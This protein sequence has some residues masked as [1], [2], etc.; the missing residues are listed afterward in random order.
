MSTKTQR[1]SISV[2]KRRNPAKAISQFCDPKEVA[3]ALNSQYTLQFTREPSGPLPDIV[4]QPVTPMPEIVF[5]VPGI[6][7]L[8]CNLNPAKASGPDLVPARILKLAS[9]EIV[10]ILCTIFQQS[11][12][13]SKVPLDWQMANFKCL[14]LKKGDKTNPANYRLVS[15]TC[16]A[17]KS[18]EHTVYS[19]IMTH[20][21][22]HNILVEFQHGFRS[23]HSCDTELLNTIE[24]LS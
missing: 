14:F 19:Q 9:Q 16:I 13:T 21:D 15:L 7:K 22:S 3:Q 11:F 23:S 5:N 8:L 6:E 4:G 24:E 12:N 18:R 10:P 1:N 20:L 2:S 17:C